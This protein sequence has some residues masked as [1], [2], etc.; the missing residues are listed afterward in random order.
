[1]A[2]RRFQGSFCE[3]GCTL[4]GG[5]L[6]FTTAA[7]GGGRKSSSGEGEQAQTSIEGNGASSGV[8][9]FAVRVRNTVVTIVGIATRIISVAKGYSLKI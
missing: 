6:L 4:R 9:V 7:H 3:S 1:M 2:A 8:V 5:L